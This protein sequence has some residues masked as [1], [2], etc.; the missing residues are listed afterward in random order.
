MASYLHAAD[1][2]AEGGL[3]GGCVLGQAA[4]NVALLRPLVPRLVAHL[5]VDDGWPV[6]LLRH[7]L[8]LQ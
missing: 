6:I 3:C 8:Q 2:E 5:D 1:L 7:I 4:L